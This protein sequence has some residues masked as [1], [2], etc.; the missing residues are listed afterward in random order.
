EGDTTGGNEAAGLTVSDA[1]APVTVANTI[2]PPRTANPKRAS[3]G[4]ILLL[5]ILSP[6][7][8]PQILSFNPNVWMDNEKADYIKLSPVPG[9]AAYML[10]PGPIGCKGTRKPQV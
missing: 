1:A 6:S 10:P 7:P 5:N 3:F 4:P 2:A 9:N 8:E